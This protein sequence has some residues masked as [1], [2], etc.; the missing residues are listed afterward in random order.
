MG[1]KELVVEL[2]RVSVCDYMHLKECG[3][4]LGKNEDITPLVMNRAEIIAWRHRKKPFPYTIRKLEL[5]DIFAHGVSKKEILRRA[6]SAQCLETPPKP[7]CEMSI[8]DAKT[9]LWFF[10]SD[11][12]ESLASFVGLNPDAVRDRL[13]SCSASDLPPESAWRLPR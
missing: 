10:S 12:F 13:F 5:S 11:Y 9:L 3:V 1:Y 2:I 8:D 7:L 4:V 6:W